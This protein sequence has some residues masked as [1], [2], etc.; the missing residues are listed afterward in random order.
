MSWFISRYSYNVLLGLI[1]LALLAVSCAQ[2]QPTPTPT[3]KPSAPSQPKDTPA[4]K[5]TQP[6][7]SAKPADKAPQASPAA[8]KPTGAPIKVGHI[9]PMSGPA[10]DFGRLDKVAMEIAVEDINN[11]GGINGA[12]L[13]VILEDGP[14]DPKQ[15]PDRVR[16]LAQDDKVFA[17]VG[18]YS[19]GEFQVAAPLAVDLQVP[20]IGTKTGKPGMTASNR[21]W[22]FVMTVVDDVSMPASVKAYKKMF[23]NVKKVVIAGDIKEAVTENAIRVILPK[24]LKEEGFEVIDTVGY[25]SRTTDFSAV[26]TKIKGANPEGLV[27]DATPTGNPV[28]FAKELERQGVKVPT[29]GSIHL[30]AGGFV[31]AAGTA[32]EGWFVPTFTDLASTDPT[33]K[34]FIAKFEKKITQDSNISKDSQ[35]TLEATTYD[36]MMAMAQI[37]RQKSITPST[38]LQQARNTIKDGLASLKDYKGVNGNISMGANGEAT[39]AP[40]YLVAKGGKW[41]GIKP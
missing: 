16:K 32:M 14:F 17:I 20:M 36:A 27:Y 24:A 15:V 5:A 39:W 10:V 38:P 33:T 34:D 25:E 22:S 41:V 18:P 23:P 26:V 7:A 11:S 9:T 12:P 40:F 31:T 19:T 6:S 13:Q 4:A 3:P 29:L 2:A 35:V 30:I 21:P 37:M 8:A 1:L 28:Q